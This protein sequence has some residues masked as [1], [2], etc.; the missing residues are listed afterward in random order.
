MKKINSSIKTVKVSGQTDPSCYVDCNRWLT[1]GQA[2]VTASTP[3]AH[4]GYCTENRCTR[5][6]I[7]DAYFSF[8]N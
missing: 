5:E 6:L 3:E 7:T 8:E 2:Y 1:D 4:W